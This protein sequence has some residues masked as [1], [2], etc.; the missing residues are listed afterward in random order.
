MK[1]HS[2][3]GPAVQPDT[4]KDRRQ[5]DRAAA[6]QKR[7]EKDRLEKKREEER[8][9][10]EI[11]HRDEETKKERDARDRAVRSQQDNDRTA[12]AAAS[13]DPVHKLPSIPDSG[14]L[15]YSNYLLTNNSI[16]NI[17]FVFSSSHR[18]S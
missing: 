17:T 3:L 18:F 7:H 8:R 10:L 6:D 16:A 15:R 2:K 4:A 14:T 11:R 9:E 12:A 5:A 1:V 13:T